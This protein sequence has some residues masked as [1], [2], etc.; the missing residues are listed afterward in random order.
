MTAEVR[1]LLCCFKM[2]SLFSFVAARN[3]ENEARPHRHAPT[4]SRR[5]L[6]ATLATSTQAPP[7]AIRT[8]SERDAESEIILETESIVET[9]SIFEIGILFKIGIGRG[10]PAVPAPGG[11]IT[12]AQ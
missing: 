4:R 5:I 8:Q 12:L 10:L 3:G 9:E 2:G 1:A 6:S 11:G 7:P